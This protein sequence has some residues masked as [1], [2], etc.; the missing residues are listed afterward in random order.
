M[1]SGIGRPRRPPTTPTAAPSRMRHDRIA[2][3]VFGVQKRSRKAIGAEATRGC[4][5]T[6][7]RQLGPRVGMVARMARGVNGSASPDASASLIAA[8][9]Q[10]FADRGIDGV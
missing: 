10:L 1:A 4:P 8:A 9:E 7:V 3:A 6:S 2:L 5:G